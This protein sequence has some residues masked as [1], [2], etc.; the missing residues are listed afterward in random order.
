MST[1]HNQPF[2]PPVGIFPA[3]APPGPPED[4]NITTGVLRNEEMEV[5]LAFVDLY[6]AATQPKDR[7]LL[8]S[9][10]VLPL[11]RKLNRNMN[12]AEW[13]LQKAVCVVI[14]LRCHC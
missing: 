4:P 11:I 12:D 5:I 3:S 7:H 14:L 8:L 13:K 1:Q 6:K 2:P 10:Q 9:E